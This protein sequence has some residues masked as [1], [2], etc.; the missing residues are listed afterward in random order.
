MPTIFKEVDFDV[1]LD[2]F[3]DE[4]L[5]DE[6]ERRGLGADTVGDTTSTELIKEIYA[7]RRLGQDYQKE[8]NELIYN[9]VGKIV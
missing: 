6:L 3:T 5:I 1:E 7:K 9:V 4:D 2:D 8:L